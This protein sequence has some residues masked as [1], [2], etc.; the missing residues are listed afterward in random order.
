LRLRRHSFELNED[1]RRTMTPT[2]ETPADGFQLDATDSVD[3]GRFDSDELGDSGGTFQA[4]RASSLS[5]MLHY[6]T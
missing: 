6:I 4:F 1:Q 3:I 5:F 2:P